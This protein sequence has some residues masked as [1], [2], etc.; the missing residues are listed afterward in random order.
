MYRHRSYPL[1]PFSA[2]VTACEAGDADSLDRLLPVNLRLQC[3]L[4]VLANSPQ[5]EPTHH[6]QSPRRA[7]TTTTNVLHS[8]LTNEWSHSS[9]SSWVSFATNPPAGFSLGS[10]G[11]EFGKRVLGITSERAVSAFNS[12]G[13]LLFS[14]AGGSEQ[15]AQPFVNLL[16][17]PELLSWTRSCLGPLPLM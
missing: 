8:D 1:P 15:N 14:S 3:S 13:G 2:V 11:M 10:T 4:R 7:T 17:D 12:L 9:S 5:M 16:S 6:P